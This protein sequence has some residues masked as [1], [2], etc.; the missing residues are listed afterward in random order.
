MRLKA[1][2]VVKIA[3]EIPD[4]I[5][6][7]VV[8]D[9]ADD[10]SDIADE[11]A[12]AEGADE[13]GEIADKSAE[14]IADE[15]DE[16]ADA[17]NLIRTDEI[18]DDISDGE[19]SDEDDEIA[20]ESAESIADEDDEIAD[21]VNLIH[22]DE[23]PD[24]IA[25][26]EIADEDDEISD[27]S[28]EEIADEDDQLVDE[29]MRPENLIRTALPCGLA[30]FEAVA[31][32]TTFGDGKAFFVARCRATSD[33]E[34]CGAVASL[35]WEKQN[36]TAAFMP[37][38]DSVF[39]SALSAV[40][41]SHGEGKLESPMLPEVSS[42]LSSLDNTVAA[43]PRRRRRRHRRRAHPL[44]TSGCNWHCYLGRYPD[45]QKAFGRFNKAKAHRH[46]NQ[47]GKR[48]KRSCTCPKACNW[49]C[50]LNRYPD[51]QRAFGTTNTAKAYAHW[52]NHG[53]REGRVCTCRGACT[54]IKPTHHYP[55][56]GKRYTKGLPSPMVAH[57]SSMTMCQVQQL[58]DDCVNQINKFR[59]GAPFSDGRK[60]PH[61]TLAALKLEPQNFS[62][63]MNEKATS[64]LYYSV[65]K[66][67]GCGHFSMSL[68]CGLKRFVPAEN[69]CCPRNCKTYASCKNVLFDCLKQM[70][71]EG[72]I[73]LDTGNTKW[74]PNTG[75][76]LAM[77]NAKSTV[78]CG[79]GFD[80]KGKMLATQ[81][82][83]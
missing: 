80:S 75:H 48:E 55:L 6:K 56:P 30:D 52:F 58:Q 11:I 46:W 76:Y 41:G 25:D 49:Q 73:V 63:C 23:I 7:Y 62:K 34:V 38:D 72:K 21:A 29:A 70:W 78:A 24:E 43:K 10:D 37:A 60:R 15:E 61:G 13:D 47:H 2:S 9:I 57:P 19:G 22:T 1:G 79:F 82:L 4:N 12:D 64:D 77:V 27:E 51:L 18:A 69:S 42:L 32:D 28:V 68:D 44:S 50:Y 66:N 45:L 33:P 83:F 67:K 5:M 20:D 8:G 74:T 71:D 3:D 53:I 36:L 26:D 54:G 81:N 39:C 14:E 40:M 31:V 16:I 59:A 17:V 65:H 35:I